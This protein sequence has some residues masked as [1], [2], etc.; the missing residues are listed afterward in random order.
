MRNSLSVK[1]AT[2]QP[3][4]NAQYTLSLVSKGGAG[5]GEVTTKLLIP[6]DLKTFT[7]YLVTYN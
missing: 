3:L 4:L 1:T 6:L 7:V 2:T 5:G